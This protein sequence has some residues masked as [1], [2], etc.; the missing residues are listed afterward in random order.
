MVAVGER[1]TVYSRM[2]IVDATPSDLTW[3]KYDIDSSGSMSLRRVGH[4]EIPRRPGVQLLLY[5]NRTERDLTGS[6]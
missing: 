3:W 1:H 6:S 2:S 4:R 5:V